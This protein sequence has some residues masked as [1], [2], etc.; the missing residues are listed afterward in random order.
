MISQLSQQI[1]ELSATS[2]LPP[3]T[4]ELAAE[5]GQYPSPTDP[6]YSE[7]AHWDWPPSHEDRLRAYRSLLAERTVADRFAARSVQ[8]S[9]SERSS[10][11]RTG[12]LAAEQRRLERQTA[13]AQK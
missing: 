5:Y 9:R 6:Y 2:A 4:L 3:S 11:Q 1:R 7:E 13:R 10:A 12:L 8:P